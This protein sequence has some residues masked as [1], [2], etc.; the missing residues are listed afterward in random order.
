[1]AQSQ[2]GQTLRSAVR[3]TRAGWLLRHNRHFADYAGAV[4]Q[5]VPA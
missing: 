5:I 2:A 4:V 1:M 3:L